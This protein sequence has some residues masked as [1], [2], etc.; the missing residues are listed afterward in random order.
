[1]QRGELRL[2]PMND[3]GYR[4]PYILHQKRIYNGGP[5]K[6]SRATLRIELGRCEPETGRAFKE[7]DCEVTRNR[8]WKRVRGT[9]FGRYCARRSV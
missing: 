8:W 3:T 5:T 6:I 4:C 7:E 1:M 2:R 9:G